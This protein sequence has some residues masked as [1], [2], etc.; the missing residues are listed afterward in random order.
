M[1]LFLNKMFSHWV[2]AGV[3]FS[4]YIKLFTQNNLHIQGI[5]LIV[6]LDIIWGTTFPLVEKTVT[7][8]SPSV[9]IATRFTVAAVFFSF[10]LRRLNWLILRDGLLL[11][12]LFF[13]CLATETIALETTHANQASFVL[14]LSAIIVPLLSW[15]FGRRLPWKTFLSAGLA[16][17]GIGVMFWEK[18]RLETGDLLLFFAALLYAIYTL[19]LEQ[20]APRHPPLTLTSIQLFT[21]AILGIFWSNTKLIEELNSISENWAVIVYL[22]L[23]ATAL[24]IWLQTLAQRWMRSEEAALLYTL[25]PI[26]SSIFS[27]LLLGEKFGI[28]GIIGATLVLSAIVFSQ[29]SQ[30]IQPEIVVE[31]S[32]SDSAVLVVSEANCQK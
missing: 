29:K 11:G 17:I 3:K 6:I 9:I 31:I 21:T 15:L 10:N 7:N 26:F 2:T 30:N 1:I 28:N 5:I 32:K 22:G 4:N 25:E 14:S 16:V 23:V 27:F 8:L 20:A 13:S 18:G 24:V 19:K 12:L